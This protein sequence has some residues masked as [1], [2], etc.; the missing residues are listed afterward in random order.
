MVCN[1]LQSG[2]D[3]GAD[4]IHGHGGLKAGD[5]VALAVDEELGEVPLDV[6][7]VLIVL[8][9]LLDDAVQ[10]QSSRAVETLK[11]G[12]GGKPL[13]ERDGVLAVDVDLGI[14]REGD[15]ETAGA[16]GVDLFI[17]SG[18]L[19]GELVAG[20]V[21]NLKTLVLEC[22]VN[23]LELL[24]LGGVKPQ[25]VAVLTTITTLPAKSESATSAP[26]RVLTVK[27][28]RFM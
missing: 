5:N 26:L 23:L 10:N 2:F 1:T 24:I 21:E 3:G 14:L 16:E 11:P 25:P 28:Y 20:E 4:F 7:V 22:V 6:T 17:G 18:S 15:P 8:V 13:V 27:S 9:H 19:I 12:V